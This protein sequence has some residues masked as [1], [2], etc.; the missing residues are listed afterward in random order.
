MIIEGVRLKNFRSHRDTRLTLERGTTVIIGEN[1]AG[2][3]SILDAIGFALFKARPGSVGV[4]ELISLGEREAEV[5]VD[6]HSNG[7][8]Y[9]VRRR[10]TKK[11]G[12][13]SY[14]YLLGAERETLLVKGER[15]VTVE[16][17]N[18]LGMN[19][20]LFTSAV[21]IRQGEIDRLLASDAGTRKQ[22]IGRLIGTEDLESAHKNILQIIKEFEG[23][24][25]GLS[26][27]PGELGEKKEKL[28][29]LGGKITDSKTELSGIKKEIKTAKTELGGVEKRK[30]LLEE[31]QRRAQEIEKERMQLEYHE[32][33]LARIFEYEALLAESEPKNARAGE[34][35]KE[36]ERLQSE[37]GGFSLAHERVAG[38]RREIERVTGEVTT[39]GDRLK[40]IFETA[41]QQLRIE[42]KKGSQLKES[43]KTQN[44]GLQNELKEARQNLEEKTKGLGEYNA[45][46]DSVRK[47]LASLDDAVGSCPVCDRELTS[48]HKKELQRKY[49]S[50]KKTF[51]EG[52]SKLASEI[53]GLRAGIKSV[54]EQIDAVA[55][56]NVESAL[57]L[58]AGLAEHGKRAAELD[59]QLKEDRRQLE[60][61]PPLLKRQKGLEADLSAL[62]PFKA[63]HTEALGFLRKNLSQKEELKKKTA[64]LRRDMSGRGKTLLG[65]KK[66]AV[67][68]GETFEGALEKTQNDLRN[69]QN[70]LRVIERTEAFGAAAV[71]VWEKRRSELRLEIKK[72][73]ELSG[74]LVRLRGFKTLVEKIRTVFHKDRLQREL[75]KRAKPLI[76]EYTRE[77][78]NGFNLPYT[79]LTITDDYSLTLHSPKGAETLDMLSGGERIAAALALRVGLSRALSGSMLELIILDEPT[80]H[81]DAQ[82]RRELVDIVKR[83]ATIPQTIVVTHDK[84]FEEAADRIIE[85]EKIN[86]V[87]VVR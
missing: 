1:G 19:G 6:F 62:A 81:L 74:E 26:R 33:E 29:G 60:T 13:E 8:R 61:L 73:E 3:T 4:D 11:R 44:A 55:K 41:S 78:F 77:V 66:K 59:G 9:R 23:K 10:R 20:E 22:H 31:I 85:V 36:L 15:E 38:L 58:E 37:I 2:K 86:G 51:K 5:T 54:E 18:T 84:E 34:I 52:I 28:K 75:R 27:V 14:F 47:A 32:K 72:L 16:V 50:E 63:A 79:D 17:E 64:R 70:R 67:S 71:E 40:K 80:I 83:L 45:S 65:L 21:Y 35:E 7:R 87:S 39:L 49:T 30:T 25:A 48:A 42:I 53:K 43:V 69:L 46:L 76:E 57:D 12:A 56:I 24:I 68:T 82:R